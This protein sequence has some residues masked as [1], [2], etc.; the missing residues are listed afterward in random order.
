MTIAETQ[1]VVAGFSSGN[2]WCFSDVRCWSHL[3]RA[4]LPNVMVLVSW[5]LAPQPA[6][7]IS[8]AVEPVVTVAFIPLFAREPATTTLH[9]RNGRQ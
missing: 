7:A 1:V 4:M 5:G 3:S 6:Q 9:C 8:V 2:S